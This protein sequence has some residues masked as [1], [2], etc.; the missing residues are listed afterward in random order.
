MITIEFPLRTFNCFWRET[1][2]NIIENEV[3]TMSEK[4]QEVRKRRLGIME[5]LRN[6]AKITFDFVLNALD[7][8]TEKGDYL[9]F[10]LFIA[11]H[12]IS[13]TS[14]DVNYRKDCDDVKIGLHYHYLFFKMLEEMFN[15]EEGFTAKFL[16]ETMILEVMD[17]EQKP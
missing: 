7:E 12:G 13:C 6:S 11:P 15:D 4:A 10:N 17:M 3:L 14:F 5:Y 2:K 9:P 1:S 8:K 16:L